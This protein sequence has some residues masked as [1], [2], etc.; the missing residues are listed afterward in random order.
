MGLFGR[1]PSV[2]VPTFVEELIR[3]IRQDGPS[4]RGDRVDHL[5]KF[6]FRVLQFAQRSAEC[7]LRSLACPRRHRGH[8]KTQSLPDQKGI[9][10]K[11]GGFTSPN[12]RAT[13]DCKRSVTCIA[14]HRLP[15]PVENDAAD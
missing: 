2:L 6:S 4:Q 12:P 14:S 8:Y 3:T 13:G 1:K 5:P 15:E 11:S 7:P 9:P 10:E